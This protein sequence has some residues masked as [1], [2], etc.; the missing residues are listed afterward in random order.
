MYLQMEREVGLSE[1]LN[2]QQL[3]DLYSEGASD[4]EIARAMKVTI[5][6]F[7]RLCEEVPDFAEFVERGR[8]LAQAWW[9]EQGRTNL[10]RKDFNIALY[11]FNMK[12]R[13]GWADKVDTNDTTDKN[14]VDLNQAKG[15][16][17]VLLGKIAKKHPE[18]LSGVN[19]H[20]KSTLDENED[21]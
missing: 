13:H 14:P 17:Q 12:N 8:T 20:Q 6:K 15:Q 21:D 10:W 19:L 3:L 2:G 7:Y 5:A 4:V 11:N 16:L 18:L 9:Y 1:K